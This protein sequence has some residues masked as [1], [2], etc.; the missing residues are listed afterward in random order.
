MISAQFEGVKHI[1]DFETIQLESFW[2][3]VFKFK[4]KALG[5]NP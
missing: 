1:T 2:T 3:L 4:V 5:Q